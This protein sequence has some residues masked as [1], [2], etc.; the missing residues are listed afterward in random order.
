MS[1][2]A[3]VPAFFWMLLVGVAGQ[4]L[5]AFL[6]VRMTKYTKPYPPIKDYAGWLLLTALLHGLGGASVF[7]TIH[8]GF[9]ALLIG[10]A[11][12]SLSIQSMRH[13]HSQFT[14]KS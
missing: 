12:L 3:S 1:F 5:C 10:M 2:L 7:S 4:S 8:Y 6:W 13:V 11:F 14:L 9:A